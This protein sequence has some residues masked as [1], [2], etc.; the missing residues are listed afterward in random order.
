[1]IPKDI[2]VIFKED[3]MT[4]PQNKSAVNIYYIFLHDNFLL[5]KMSLKTY[6]I[7]TSY[8]YPDFQET[9]HLNHQ[10]AKQSFVQQLLPSRIK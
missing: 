4:F 10:T 1:M 7:F 5:K 3:C 2:T 8:L 9:Q 6:I